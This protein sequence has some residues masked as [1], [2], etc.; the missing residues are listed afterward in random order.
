MLRAV[1]T[2]TLL[3]ANTERV[4]AHGLGAIPDAIIH[5]TLTTTANWLSWLT[6]DTAAAGF[7]IT[8]VYCAANQIQGRFQSVA[9]IWQGRSY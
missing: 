5:D 4:T 2:G 7:D 9:I 3:T 1:L 8:N 6:T